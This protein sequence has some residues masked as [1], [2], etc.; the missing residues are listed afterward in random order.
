[1]TKL[2]V[3]LEGVNDAEYCRDNGSN[4]YAGRG[5][6]QLKVHPAAL[7]LATH[8]RSTVA[9]SASH[10]FW[11]LSFNSCQA[12]HMTY[13]ICSSAWHPTYNK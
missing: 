1:M 10:G 7:G 12:A 6:Q 9:G 4:L 11:A 5:H 3:L 2:L 13:P 8:G